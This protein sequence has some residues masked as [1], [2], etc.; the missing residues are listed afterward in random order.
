MGFKNKTKNGKMEVG[1]NLGK[2]VCVRMYLPLYA[3]TECV[4]FVGKPNFCRAIMSLKWCGCNKMQLKMRYRRLGKAERKEERLCA[5]QK[6]FFF[7]S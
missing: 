6:L 7:F 3:R 2:G 5:A 1:S 4:W